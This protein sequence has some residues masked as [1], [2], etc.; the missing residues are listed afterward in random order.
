MVNPVVAR[1]VLLVFFKLINVVLNVTLVKK[2]KPSIIVVQLFVSNV[3]PDV[4]QLTTKH[5][6]VPIVR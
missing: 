6:F 4:L 2:A 5:I 3:M 1:I